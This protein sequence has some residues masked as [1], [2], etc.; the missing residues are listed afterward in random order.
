MARPELFDLA[1]EVPG[2]RDDSVNDDDEKGFGSNLEVELDLMT[3]NVAKS[4]S[5][6]Y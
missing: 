6:S 1:D 3:F 4:V 2:H 5:R